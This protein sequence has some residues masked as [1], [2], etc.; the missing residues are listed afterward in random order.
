M[1]NPSTGRAGSTGEDTGS[2]AGGR[3]TAADYGTWAVFALIAVVVLGRMLFPSR[4][5]LDWQLL[6]LLVLVVAVVKM[7]AISEIVLNRSGLTIRSKARK[8]EESTAAID[9]EELLR[10]VTARGLA[11]E[12]PDEPPQTRVM[13]PGPADGTDP[14]LETDADDDL[15]S[16]AEA[17][18]DDDWAAEPEPHDGWEPPPSADG[19]PVSSGPPPTEAGSDDAG[20]PDEA[21]APDVPDAAET[22]DMAETPD[23]VDTTDSMDAVDTTDAAAERAEDLRECASD[24][25]RVAVVD[26]AMEVEAALRDLLDSEGALPD[27]RVATPE[28]LALL[29]ERDLLTASVRE[30]IADIWEIRNEVVHGARVDDESASQVVEA[31]IRLLETLDRYRA[32]IRDDRPGR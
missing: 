6:V 18:S 7:D 8:L 25:P 32:A 22:P 17:G 5:V 31:A 27:R 11:V 10:S 28:L 4:V 3:T 12:L 2:S 24:D 19:E 13:E 1:A 16:D 23:A 21:D 14:A 20:A 9:E 30:A 15:E 26:A 29:E